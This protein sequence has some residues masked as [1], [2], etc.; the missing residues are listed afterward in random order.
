MKRSASFRLGWA[1]LGALLVTLAGGCAPARPALPPAPPPKPVAELE[2]WKTPPP[3]AADRTALDLKLVTSRARLDNGLS[4]TVVARPETST[5]SVLLWVPEAGDWTEG[6]VAAMAEALHAGTKVGGEV[7]IN[8]RLDFQQVNVATNAAGTS[9]RWN[10]MPDA[11]HKAIDLLAAFVTKPAFDPAETRVKLRGT[12]DAI[13][14]FSSGPGNLD[15][16]NQSTLIG[17]LPTPEEDA[18]ALIRLKLEDLAKIHACTMLPGRAELVVVGP[19]SSDD[20][21]SWA[22]AAFAGWQ[23]APPANGSCERWRAGRPSLTTEAKRLERTQLA[24]AYVGRPEPE[25]SMLLP[26]PSLRSEDYV[27]YAV[28]ARA[29]FWRALTSDDTLRHAGA[30]YTINTQIDDAYSNFSL[31]QI[32]GLLEPSVARESL[33]R[34]VEDNWSL[35]ETLT[36]ADLDT[37]KRMVRTELLSDLAYNARFADRVLWLLRQGQDPTQIAAWLDGISR[38]DLERGRA[39]ARR[40]LQDT[41]P[42]IM[43]RAS[44]RKIT[45]GLGLDVQLRE[46]YI[47]N[48]PVAKRKVGST[49]GV[50]AP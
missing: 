28:L 39:V 35:S 42:S 9:F 30:T 46:L 20:V 7:M 11:T 12:I 26:G 5:T 33:R 18:L 38:I 13:Q 45:A 19:T 24:I 1:R 34:L 48:D 37:A 17:N 15:R 21:T 8:P 32:G 31:L 29:L 6:P 27:T 44:A 4:V 25:I 36:Q 47:T 16:V 3:L 43:V 40:W 41:K 10:V 22:R 23:T 2:R 14:R 49:G 50:H